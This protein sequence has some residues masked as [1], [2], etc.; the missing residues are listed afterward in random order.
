MGHSHAENGELVRFA[1]QSGARGDHVAQLCDV[2]RHLV[3]T[4]T[5]DLAV[6]FPASKNDGTKLAHIKGYETS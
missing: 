1:S 3:A 2:C 4:S 5:F 6:V